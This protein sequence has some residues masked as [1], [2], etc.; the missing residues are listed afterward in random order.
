MLFNSGLFLQFFAAFLLCYYAVR[1]NLQARNWLIVAASYVFYGAWDARFLL[2]LIGTSLIDYFVAIGLDRAKS[3]GARRWLLSAS[4]AGNLGVLGFFKYYGFFVESMADL[5]RVLGVQF[6]M[7]VLEVVLPV[8]ISFYTFQTMSYTIDVYRG[9]IRATRDLASFLA[10]VSFFPQLVAGPIERAAHLLPQFQR[11]VSITRE[12]LREGLWLMIWGM[13]K[14]VA[15]ADNLAPLVEMVYGAEQPSGPMTILATAAFALQIYCDFSGY[16]DIARGT[17]RVLGFEIMHNFNLPYSA[18]SLR[19]FW[20]RWHVSLSTWLRDYLYIP[21]G[22]NRRGPARTRINLMVTMLLGGLW[23]GANWTF[24]L[25]GLWH[26]LAL[27]L[28]RARGAWSLRGWLGT[29]LA[30]LY[31]WML[32]RA[33]SLEHLGRL[34]RAFLSWSAPEWVGSYAMNLGF[35][36][37]PLVLMELWQRRR[38][39]VLAPLR[40]PAWKLGV[41]EG[42]CLVAIVVFWQREKAP[43]IYFQF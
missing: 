20:G 8:G 16:S 26:G 15:L 22:G 5:L 18:A 11:T 12:M 10:Y 41:L 39:D 19:E 4:L 43:F 9:Q 7:R 14:K 3:E 31:G 21:L 34:H 36:A 35:F 27:A 40:L 13:F 37:A 30:V 38:N 42:V 1:G 29:M 24:V 23:H 2:L 17:A 32:F 28:N 33:E 25:W 6:E